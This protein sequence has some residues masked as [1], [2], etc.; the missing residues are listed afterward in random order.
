[1]LGSTANGEDLDLLCCIWQKNHCQPLP[2][3]PPVGPTG[4]T[5][6]KDRFFLWKKHPATEARRRTLL[7]SWFWTKGRE[8]AAAGEHSPNFSLCDMQK[9]QH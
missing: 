7:I 6:M 3:G 9:E 4:E 1:M 2:D 5:L 8:N